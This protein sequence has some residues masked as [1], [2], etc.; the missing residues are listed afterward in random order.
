MERQQAVDKA[1]SPIPDDS[2]EFGTRVSWVYALNSK[3]LDDELSKFAMSGEG[4][5]RDQK[6]RKLVKFLRSGPSPTI[7][8]PSSD[9]F[10]WPIAGPSN[11][12]H[13]L[14]PPMVPPQVRVF[15]PTIPKT[16]GEQPVAYQSRPENLEIFKWNLRFDGRSDPASFL[17]RLED[18]RLHYQATPESLLAALP[19]ILEGDALQWYRNGHR[20]WSRYDD[21]LFEFR[22][23]YFPV[24]YLIDLEA[25]IFN[26]RQR[27]GE[28]V[29]NYVTELR[30]LI[31]RH[32]GM[33]ETQEVSRIYH[34]LLP[35]YRQFIWADTFSDLAGLVQKLRQVEQVAKE[36][37][38]P[39]VPVS[40][41]AESEPVAGPSGG[42]TPG[43]TV[44]CFRCGQL[45]H[46]RNTCKNPEQ[47][48]CSKCLRKG[49]WARDCPCNN[50][51]EN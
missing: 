42:R 17:E 38:R 47:K 51:S 31:R 16:L 9:G 39:S 18:I 13:S 4:L 15:E 33:N 5:N 6:R 11:G 22:A 40:K 34:N 3:E 10:T 29:Q 27:M 35:E 45:G 46:Y 2:G 48:F 8:A 49:V 25:E 28:S 12:V 14:Q 32:G 37:R 24:N 1:T 19:Q 50:R 36:L 26:R 20:N 30:T 43:A 21:F 41:S 7:F 44:R 23:F